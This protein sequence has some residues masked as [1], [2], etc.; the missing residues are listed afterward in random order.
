M[1]NHQQQ[2]LYLGID[3][4]VSGGIA[5]VNQSGKVVQLRAMPQV[6]RDIWWVISSIVADFAVIE[7]VSGYIG[8]GG[9]REKGGGA[10]NAHSMGKFLRNAGM[11][12]GF[13]TAAEIPFTETP[14]QVWQAALSVPRPTSKAGLKSRCCQLFPRQRGITLQTCDALLIAEFCRRTREALL[15]KEQLP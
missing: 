2:R 12:I 5:V 14:P 10:A 3:P 9:D 15:V 8:K 7:R 11:L 13:L 1:I 6:P 4:G